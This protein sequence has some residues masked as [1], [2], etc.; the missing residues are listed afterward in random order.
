MPFPMKT[1]V[2]QQREGKGRRTQTDCETSC[3][4]IVGRRKEHCRARSSVDGLLDVDNG[5]G[6]F[7]PEP[8][9]LV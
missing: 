2:C 3:E 8:R 1:I 6:N 4:A 5:Y 7:A 9:A